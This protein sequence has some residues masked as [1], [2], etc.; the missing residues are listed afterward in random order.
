ML[1]VMRTFFIVAVSF[2]SN[3]P[4]SS[5]GRLRIYAKITFPPTLC[6]DFSGQLMSVEGTAAGGKAVTQYVTLG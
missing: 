3:Q 2:V 5:S 1:K 6:R 4:G